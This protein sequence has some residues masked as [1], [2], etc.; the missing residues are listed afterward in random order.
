MNWINILND[1][2]NYIESNLNSEISHEEISKISCCSYYHFQ[3]VFSYIT[4]LSL[5]EY[6][7]NRKMTLAAF[8][9]QKD[10]GRIIDIAYKYGYASPN[11][12]NKAFKSVHGIPPIKA[13]NNKAIL[14]IFPKLSLSL[15][16]SGT[17][18]VKYSIVEK[19]SFKIIGNRISLSENMNENFKIVPNF[20][21]KMINNDFINKLKELNNNYPKG[22]LGVNYFKN[23]R[24]IYYYIS[25]S[26]NKKAPKN[27]YEINIPKSTWIIFKSEGDFEKSVQKIYTKF[28]KEWLP[29]SNYEYGKLPDIEVYPFDKSKNFEVWT[30]IKNK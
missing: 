17:E 7:R 22:I 25:V 26:S 11:S 30:S 15:E 2:I 4:G 14:N 3:K 6:I 29:F 23:S 13:K 9:I 12:F 8:D 10:E 1:V 28:F 19:E 21:K 18:D 27:M 24:Y 20:W 16:I 5:G